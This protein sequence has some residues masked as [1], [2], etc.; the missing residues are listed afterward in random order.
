MPQI[1]S[2]RHLWLVGN[3][4]VV[5]LLATLPTRSLSAQSLIPG[6]SFHTLAVW[7][8]Q[9]S[10]GTLAAQSNEGIEP[11]S[12][13]IVGKDSDDSQGK[14]TKRILGMVPNFQAV[15]ADTYLPPL[16]FK[17]KFWLA[18]KS[19][20][21]YSSF[22]FV[23]I[24]A[25]VEEATNTYPEF[26]Q[27]AAGFGRYYWHTFAD[28]TS[29]NYLTGAIFP[30]ITHEDPRYYTLYHGG[31]LRRT[32]YAMSRVLITRN[33]KGLNTFNYSEVLGNGAATA[34]GGFYYP[35]RERVGLGET[36][37]RWAMQILTDAVGN[38]FEEFWPDINSKFFHER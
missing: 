37:E 30:S 13:S 3:C 38:V 23:G 17:Q 31:F 16:S 8:D 6:I 28:Q 9:Q 32:E 7:Q 35:E 26:H 1:L 12:S 27:G 36:C 2:K 21:D 19:S 11:S 10:D 22:V 14:Q 24:Q 25:G 18:T 33:D 20:F 29:G 34:L 4:V 5:V 15:S